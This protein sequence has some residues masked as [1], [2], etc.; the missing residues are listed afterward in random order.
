MITIIASIVSSLTHRTGRFNRNRQTPMF[1]EGERERE[2]ERDVKVQRRFDICAFFIPIFRTPA[3]VRYAQTVFHT[4]G[5][6]ICLLTGE[7]RGEG[8]G[9]GGGEEEANENN[10]KRGEEKT[11]FQ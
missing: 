4:R 11:D 5:L 10:G 2:R 3:N 9:G 8:G 7:A 6:K 1:Q